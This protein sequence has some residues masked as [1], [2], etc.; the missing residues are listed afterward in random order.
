MTPIIRYKLWRI[1]VHTL[2]ILQEY[3]GFNVNSPSTF[4]NDAFAHSTINTT[5]I[6]SY[7][8]QLGGLVLTHMEEFYGSFTSPHP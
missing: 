1:M 5:K 2:E 6:S 8:I 3:A 7:Y 4:R